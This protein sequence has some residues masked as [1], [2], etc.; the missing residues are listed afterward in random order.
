MFACVRVV[1]S[2]RGCGE[3]KGG[4]A[5]VKVGPGLRQGG[6]K[7][8]ETWSFPIAT[9]AEI[10]EVLRELEIPAPDS[11]LSRP[12]QASLEIVYKAMILLLADISEEVS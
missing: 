7:M 9:C 2:S 8:E 6:C 11:L 12:D 4:G 3:G 5:V 1:C 10:K